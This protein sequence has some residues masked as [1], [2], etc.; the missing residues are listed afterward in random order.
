MPASRVAHRLAAALLGAASLAASAA[1]TQ[2]LSVSATVQAL[3]KFSSAVQTVSFGTLNPSAPVLVNGSGAAVTYKCTKGTAA[4]GV[5]AGNGNNF[6]SGSRRMTNGT[7]FIPYTLALSGDTQT[8]L[9]F[10]AAGNL[11]LTV[12]GTVA[13][14]DYQDVSAGNY[15]DT[16]LLTIT[17]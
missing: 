10:G 5:T 2:N 13:G 17:P 6:A 12:G 9:G 16:V 3:C 14:A 15:T 8:G 11:S 7:D 1:D 4:A